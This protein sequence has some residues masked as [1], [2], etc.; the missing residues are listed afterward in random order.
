MF[1]QLG[2]YS[3]FDCPTKKVDKALNWLQKQFAEI[4]G[5]VR[6]ISNPHDFGNY[7]SFEIDYPYAIEI[8]NLDDDDTSENDY[9]KK[10][11]WHD[12]ANE[13]QERYNKEFE[14]WL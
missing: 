2:T 11:N 6:K 7:P 10:D 3:T 4:E 8:I 14:Q 12:K 9:N 13:I 1:N 5:I